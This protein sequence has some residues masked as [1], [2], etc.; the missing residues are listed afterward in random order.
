MMTV[1]IDGRGEEEKGGA[2]LLTLLDWQ[3]TGRQGV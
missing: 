3:V 1:G 2:H